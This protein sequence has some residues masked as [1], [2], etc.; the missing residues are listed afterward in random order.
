M[1]ELPTVKV[2]IADGYM[3]IN[4]S[5]YDPAAHTLMSDGDRNEPVIPDLEPAYSSSRAE[6]LATGNTVTELKA[7]AKELGIKGYSRMNEKELAEAIAAAEA[8]NGGD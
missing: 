1:A 4:Q 7:I 5:D 8:D 2:A 3:I 6:E